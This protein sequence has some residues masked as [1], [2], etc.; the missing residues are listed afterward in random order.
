MKLSLPLLGKLGA[1]F[2]VALLLGLPSRAAEAPSLNVLMLGDKGHHRPAD[3]HKVLAPALAK[4]A[5]IRPFAA[6]VKS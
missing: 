4:F 5:A 3:L 2:A 1:A 6:S